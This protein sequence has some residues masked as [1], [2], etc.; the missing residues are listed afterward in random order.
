MVVQK[1]NEVIKRGSKLPCKLN[2]VKLT[3]S[4]RQI[5]LNEMINVESLHSVISK[6]M[7]PGILYEGVRGCKDPSDPRGWAFCSHTKGLSEQ[8]FFKNRFP[9]LSVHK[10]LHFGGKKRF[11][12]YKEVECHQVNPGRIRFLI[13]DVFESTDFCKWGK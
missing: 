5:F 3:I 6:I 7:L 8:L 11:Y 1:E 2:F 4:T 12:S 9:I 10:I 13:E